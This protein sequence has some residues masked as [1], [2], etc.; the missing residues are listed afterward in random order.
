MNQ[1][2]QIIITTH[3][4]ILLSD[5]PDQNVIY[6]KKKK[7]LI[8]ITYGDIKTFGNNVH[9]LYLNAF[10]LE[11]QGVIGAFAEKKI[12]AVA[13]EI[14]NNQDLDR[15]K[16]KEIEKIINCIGENVLKNRL[17]ELLHKNDDLTVLKHKSLGDKQKREIEDVLLNLRKQKEQLEKLINQLEE[18]E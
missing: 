9:T 17:K 10:F 12:N 3:S 16:I 1:N 14:I 11:N 18:L 6:M 8:D 15:K 5:F 4:P 7:D 13:K 2:I